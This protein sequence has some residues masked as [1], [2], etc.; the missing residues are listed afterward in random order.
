[1]PLFDFLHHPIPTIFLIRKIKNQYIISLKISPS[2]H[3]MNSEIFIRFLS[4]ELVYDK[5]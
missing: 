2:G 3:P 1:M 4:A 5:P